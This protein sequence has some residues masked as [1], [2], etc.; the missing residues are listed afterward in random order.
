[1]EEAGCPASLRLKI[2]S[3]HI[4]SLIIDNPARNHGISVTSAATGGLPAACRVVNRFG[5]GAWVCIDD[6][7]GRVLHIRFL[8]T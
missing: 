5:G 3:Q 2:D 8:L 1:M 6:G 4:H 7:S